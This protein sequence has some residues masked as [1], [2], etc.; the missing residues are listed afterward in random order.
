MLDPE[1]TFSHHINLVARKCYY[2]LRQLRVVSRS[3]QWH[4]QEMR[5]GGTTWI[6]SLLHCPGFF[7]SSETVL[8]CFMRVLACL[9]WDRRNCN[10]CFSL[11]IFEIFTVKLAAAAECTQFPKLEVGHMPQCPIASDATALTH[12]STL[13]LVHAFVT[14]RN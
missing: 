6:F 14:S 11:V 7:S 4:R 9:L 3:L 12:Q 1:L 10:T 2:Q 13:A 5:W 8:I